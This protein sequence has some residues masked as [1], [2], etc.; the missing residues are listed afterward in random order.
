MAPWRIL[1]QL[2][3]DGGQGLRSAAFITMVAWRLHSAAFITMVARRLRSASYI[4]MLTRRLRKPVLR[5]KP[6]RK[7]IR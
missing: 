2:S 1:T 5:Q 7:T 6:N 3:R 4:T